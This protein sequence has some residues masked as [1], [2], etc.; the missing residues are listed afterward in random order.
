MNRY[1]YERK[2]IMELNEQITEKLSTFFK[3]FGDHTRLRVLNLLSEKACCVGEIAE[4]LGMEQSAISHQLKV[5]K[6]HDLVRTKQEG[7]QIY[8][9]LSDDH[10]MKIFKTGLEHIEEETD[11]K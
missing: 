5:L 8:Y 7:K 10:I 6:N 4:N 2:F 11:E 9:M 1:S 3:I